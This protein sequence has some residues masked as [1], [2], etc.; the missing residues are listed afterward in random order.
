MATAY[1]KKLVSDTRRLLNNIKRRVANV[2]RR[3]GYSPAT[4]KFRELQIP[5][6]LKGMSDKDIASF[7]RKLLY[8]QGLKTSYVK[9]AERYEKY[10][11]NVIDPLNKELEEKMWE[12]YNKFV[13]DKFIDKDMKYELLEMIVEEIT[14]KTDDEDIIRRLEEY[15]S[16]ETAQPSM[17]RDVF[18]I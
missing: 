17:W 6:T 16:Y 15:Y 10:F 4:K 7:K 14:N 12:L 18:S 3:F 11:L 1:R 9:G 13:E 5:I 8:I 2:E